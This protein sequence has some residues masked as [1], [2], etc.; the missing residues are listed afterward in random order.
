VQHAAKE[1]EAHIYQRF[2]NDAEKSHAFLVH[3]RV[4]ASKPN[5][6][7]RRTVKLDPVAEHFI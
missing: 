5:D 2:L 3:Q 4:Y 1:L 6:H 7:R